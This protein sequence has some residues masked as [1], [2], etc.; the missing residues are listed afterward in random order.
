MPLQSLMLLLSI[1]CACFYIYALV[2]ICRL[3]GTATLPD[4]SGGCSDDNTATVVVAARDEALLINEWLPPLLDQAGVQKVLFV[5]DHSSDSTLHLA[6]RVAETDDRLVVM[7]AP[8]LPPGWIGKNHALHWAA[9]R[10]DTK[11]ILFID[12]DTL[13]A[14]G[15]IRAAAERMEAEQLDELS[16]HYRIRC[17]T[18]GERIC[19][20]VFAASSAVALFAAAASSGAAIGPFNM[21]RTDFYKRIG[22][23][24]Q[25]KNA[26]VD[27]VALARLVKSNGGRAT[28]LDIADRVSI[29]LF[30]GVAGFFSS[31][32]RSSAPFLGSNTL[33]GLLCGPAVAC[34]AIATAATPAANVLLSAATPHRGPLALG[35][36]ALAYALGL[37]AVWRVQRYH[38]GNVA[39]GLLYPVPL[40]LLGLAVT[41]SVILKL[42][43]KNT[44]WRGRE[45]PPT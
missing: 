39:W 2:R 6:E 20:P 15:T 27:D 37:I 13:M 41:H 10:V 19:A 21:L 31:A 38:T 40:A 16:G 17:V 29:R 9:Q 1:I 22:G 3:K 32:A 8:E 43:G 35:V 25:I 4:A 18:A 42:R 36:A 24:D 28:F 7:Q 45:C 11:Y 5:D 23:H 30:D 44:R 34:I 14:P 33:L 12:A 26:I